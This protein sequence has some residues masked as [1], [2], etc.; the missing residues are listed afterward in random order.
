VAGWRA[1]AGDSREDGEESAVYRV[2]FARDDHQ[3][4][5]AVM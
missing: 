5:P 1:A 3:H 2:P 4:E